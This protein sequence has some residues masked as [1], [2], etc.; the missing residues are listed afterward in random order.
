[1]ALVQNRGSG[2]RPPFGSITRQ[3]N[4][5]EEALIIFQEAWW[6]ATGFL[7]GHPE[8]EISSIL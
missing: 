3:T 4:N 8:D 2:R 1:M 7:T 6:A 5:V